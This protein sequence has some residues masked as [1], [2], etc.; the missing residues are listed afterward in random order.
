MNW[1]GLTNRPYSVQIIASASTQARVKLEYEAPDIYP[2]GVKL[3]RVLSLLGDRNV[4]IQ[5]TTVTPKGIQPGQ[6]Y[7]LENSASFQQ[8]D[9]PH[10]RSWFVDAKRPTEFLPEK[11]RALAKNPE[12]FGTLDQRSGET[13]AI[14]LLS[15]PLKT[16]LKTQRHS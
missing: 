15:P 14:M 13:F 4:V 10:Y 7:V 16:E 11:E 6:A 3:E 1:M 2:A 8:A 12:Y 5:D 9:Q